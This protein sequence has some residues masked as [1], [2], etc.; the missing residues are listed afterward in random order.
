M[1]APNE[2]SPA[3]PSALPD[4]WIER[5]F[6]VMSALYGAR[7]ADLWSGTDQSAV[8]RMW[9]EKLAGFAAMPDAIKAALNALDSRPTPPNLP[10]FLAMCRQEASRFASMTPRI[11]GPQL[12]REEQAERAEKIAGSVKRGD[13]YDFL[14][15]ARRP[16]NAV[17]MAAVVEMAEQRKDSRFVQILAEL[18]EHG[19]CDQHGKLKRE[20]A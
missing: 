15:W 5:I 7:F 4:P 6:A 16:A 10:E 20:A 17:A 9:A 11:Q 8:R 12:S 3:R 2:T 13:G 1:N 19:V 18:K 14:A